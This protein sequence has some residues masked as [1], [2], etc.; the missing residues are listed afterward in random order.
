[1]LDDFESVRPTPIAYTASHLGLNRVYTGGLF[2]K[3][4]I[5]FNSVTAASLVW[6]NCVFT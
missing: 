2:L 4:T 6:I 3:I 1:M 5:N